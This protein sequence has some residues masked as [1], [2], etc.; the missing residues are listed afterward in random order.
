M[1]PIVI[2][3]MLKRQARIAGKKVTRSIKSIFKD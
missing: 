3:Q 2:K 1:K